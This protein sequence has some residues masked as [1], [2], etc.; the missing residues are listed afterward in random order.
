MPSIEGPLFR[1]VGRRL[2]R[3]APPILTTHNRLPVRA[4]RASITSEPACQP[5]GPSGALSRLFRGGPGLLNRLDRTGGGST[6]PLLA[7]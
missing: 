3:Q 6:Q 1:S 2:R 5:M 4:R 7:A